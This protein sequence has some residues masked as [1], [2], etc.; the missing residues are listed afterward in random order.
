MKKR[1]IAIKKEHEQNMNE[2]IFFLN[3]Q[4]PRKAQFLIKRQVFTEKAQAS[5][6]CQ[7]FTMP[8]LSQNLDFCTKILSCK[9]TDSHVNTFFP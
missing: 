7:I 2:K 1:L 4:V 6:L 9:L 5:E 8:C 3:E